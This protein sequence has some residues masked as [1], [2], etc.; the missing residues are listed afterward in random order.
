MGQ[1]PKSVQPSTI[2]GIKRRAKAIRKQQQCPYLVA[3]DVASQNAGFENYHHARRAIAR[4]ET[5]TALPNTFSL[6]LSAYWRDQSITPSKEGRETLKIELPR[7][8]TAFLKKHQVGR[9]RNLTGFFLESADHLEARSNFSSQS[10]ARE[11]IQRT[12]L[13][14]QFIEATGLSP[15]TNQRQRAPMEPL[16]KLPNVDHE[17]K[18]VAGSGDWIHLDEPYHH[19]WEQPELGYREDWVTKQGLYGVW[20]KWDGLYFPGHSRPYLA[21]ANQALLDQVVHIVESLPALMPG[22]LQ[23]WPWI[24]GSYWSLFVSPGRKASGLK[25]KP[26]AGTTYGWSKNATPYHSRIGFG[27][28]WRPDGVMLLDNHEAV[29]SEL[30]LLCSTSIHWAARNRINGIRSELENWLYAELRQ[31]EA[32]ASREVDDF[33]YGG[34]ARSDYQSEKDKLSAIDR[35]R[36]ILAA[37]YPD[38]KPLRDLLKSLDA[39]RDLAA[40]KM[41]K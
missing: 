11:Q 40:G 27:T 8:L 34:E 41:T 25:R 21:A 19:A 36:A 9:G 18:W 17:S 5:S 33:Y 12:A 6:Y 29:G 22:D 20:P 7:P 23:E 31:Q 15:A 24:T 10:A 37:S 38:C 28:L 4:G 14:L 32:T 16:H 3:L 35:V 1:F 13:T 2:A 39:A 26:R 30:K